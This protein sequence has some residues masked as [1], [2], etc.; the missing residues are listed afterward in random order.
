M[1]LVLLPGLPFLITYTSGWD[2]C[3]LI[4]VSWFTVSFGNSLFTTMD[5]TIIRSSRS[6]VFCK[7]RC[8]YKFCKV[9]KKTPALES[10]FYWSCR[11]TAPNV[12]KKETP[13][14]ISSCEFCEI[15]RGTFLREPFGWL[16][17]HKHSLCLLSH[18]GPSSFQER[19]HTNFPAEY[20]LGFYLCRL[21]TRV[22]SIYQTLISYYTNCT[23]ATLRDLPNWTKRMKIS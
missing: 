14:Q 2:R 5:T 7:K 21:G 22:S 23:I 13:A 10:R 1:K 16:L 6:V 3:V 9:R 20:F 11:S 4:S 19:C 17:L 18:H 8:S 15:S 12:I